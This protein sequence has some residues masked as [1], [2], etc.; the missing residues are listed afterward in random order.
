MAMA[1]MFF[2]QFS[3]INAVIF[4]LQNIFNAAGTEIDPPGMSAFIV[5]LVQVI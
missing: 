2:Q 3:G 1:L 5:V 4:Y